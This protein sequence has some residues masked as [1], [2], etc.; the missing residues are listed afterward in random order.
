MCRSISS[1]P[2]VY[3]GQNIISFHTQFYLHTVHVN[4]EKNTNGTNIDESKIYEQGTKESHSSENFSASQAKSKV[5][6]HDQ[7]VSD[8]SKLQS[9]NFK[10]RYRIAILCC[11]FLL[12][13]LELI[14]SLKGM[15]Q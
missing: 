8:N 5:V 10:K 13:V 9:A 1:I 2:C 15:M 3:F 7:D 12:I 4:N 14:K 6:F 11:L